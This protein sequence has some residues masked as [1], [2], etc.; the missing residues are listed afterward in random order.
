MRLLRRRSQKAPRTKATS[1]T[2]PTVNP[3]ISGTW[4]A[5]I[6]SA[7]KGRADASASWRT[8]Y[9]PRRKV[10]IPPHPF[11]SLA[12]NRKKSISRSVLGRSSCLRVMVCLPG[13]RFVLDQ[14]ICWV[15]CPTVFVLFNICGSEP[16]IDTEK[17]PWSMPLAP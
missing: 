12:A 9:D 6:W 7:V 13:L 10:R 5:V 2:R 4:L 8:L 15:S 14:S 11:T 16:S 17:K 3:T 1:V